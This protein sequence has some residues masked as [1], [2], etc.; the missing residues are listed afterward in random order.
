MFGRNMSTQEKLRK[1][2]RALQKTERE[3]DRERQKLE[4]QEKKLLQDI[5]KSAKAG[6]TGPLKIQA[7]D[8][9]RT[10]RYVAWPMNYQHTE[11]FPVVDIFRSFMKC[12]LRSK[13]YLSVFKL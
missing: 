9:V 10:R 4:N 1:H 6:Q 7:K 11:C 8:L 3:L 13:L 5:K 2:V 12:G